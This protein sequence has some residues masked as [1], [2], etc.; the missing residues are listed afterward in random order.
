MGAIVAFAS[1]RL[2]S[3]VVGT[4]CALVS[5]VAG[6]VGTAAAA[7]AVDP[8]TNQAAPTLKAPAND[9]AGNNLLKDVVLQWTA[10][11]HADHYVVQMSPNGD[12]TNNTVT[13]PD[14]GQTVNTVYE[15]PL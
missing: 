1:R 5:G 13:L 14:G 10:V 12:W 3:V 15:V 8:I 7:A 4:V 2:A 9:P 11:A 6:Q